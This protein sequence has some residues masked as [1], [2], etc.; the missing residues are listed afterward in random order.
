MIKLGLFVVFNSIL[1][2]TDVATDGTTFFDLNEN[3]HANW[4]AATFYFMWNPF[5]LHLLAFIYNFI[6]SWCK[7]DG[8]GNVNFNWR[9]ELKSVLFHLP[10]VVPIK[11]LYNAYRLYQL[12]FGT[13]HF[14]EKNWRKVERIQNEAGMKG[15]HESFEEAGPQAIV[16][17]VIVF[18][19]GLI[20]TAQK[21]S[22]PI[23]IFS[24][25]WGSSR[26]FFILRTRNESD[27]DPNVMMILLRILPCELLIVTNSIL[28]WTLIGG[29]LGK[30]TFIGVVLSFCTIFAT[31]YIKHMRDSRRPN[32]T[33]EGPAQE[34]VDL[35]LATKRRRFCK[36]KLFHHSLN[37]QPHQQAHPPD[38]S[39]SSGLLHHH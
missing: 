20:S 19:T 33:E 16:Q 10:F 21:V 18:S 14:D 12:G 4:A 6:N 8:E 31:L 34:Y 27:P 32:I 26:V 9:A 25:A 24:L 15:M 13:K 22:I 23:S 2:F 39:G 5:I 38:S 1:P 30:Y 28:L 17:L 11:N 7:D 3:G 35:N 29:L 36:V 37:C